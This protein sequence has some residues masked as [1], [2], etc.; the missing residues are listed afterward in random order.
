VELSVVYLNVNTLKDA[1]DQLQADYND[2]EIQ[3]VAARLVDHVRK[4]GCMVH[5]FEVKNPKAGY[6]VEIS[7]P[8]TDWA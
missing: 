1:L 8:M 4:G 2:L 6:E 3:Q 7:I 5:A